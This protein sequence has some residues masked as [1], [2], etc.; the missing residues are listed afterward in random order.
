MKNIPFIIKIAFKPFLIIFL[1]ISVSLIGFSRAFSEI[2]SLN[3]ERGKAAKNENILKTKL[4]TL[5]T[6][7]E[8]VLTNVNY[9]SSFLPGEN[10]ALLLLYQLR[11]SAVGNGLAIANFKV[12]SETKDANGLMKVSLSL[13][14]AGPLEQIINFANS[15]KTISPN[16]WIDD[17]E[18]SFTGETLRASI[19]VVSYWAPFPT[20]I[21]ALTEPITSI[22]VAEKEIL[23][24]ISTYS[25]PFFVSLTP[26]AP[27]ENLN[28]FG[29]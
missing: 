11:V 3:E 10:P 5:S 21:P 17:T 4:D 7:Q 18:L 8:N 9:A 16:V 23:S 28:P 26:M 29:E 25:Q 2:G 13:E 27:Y 14:I 20:K 19:N 24:K 12:G 1:L 22:D 6:N 15:I